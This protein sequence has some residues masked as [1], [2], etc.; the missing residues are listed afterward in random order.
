MIGLSEYG[1]DSDLE[2][3]LGARAGD[4]FRIYQNERAVNVDL[5]M[6]CLLFTEWIVA[7][8]AA[9]WLSPAIWHKSERIIHPHLWMAIIGGFSIVSLPI[10]LVWFYRGRT[11]T[12]HAVAVGQMLMSA[13]FIDISGGRIETHFH[14]FG[15]LAFLAFYRDWRILLTASAV[16]VL[17]HVIRGIWLPE[18]IYGMFT[19]SPWR[20]LEHAWWVATEDAVL[21]LSCHR[22]IREMR[23]IATREAQLWNSA[24]HDALTGLFNRRML[25]AK[26]QSRVRKEMKA[27]QP[28]SVIFI[29]LDRFKEVNDTL[30]HGIGD[31]LLIEV[32]RRLEG[33]LQG[34]D[35]V[36]R[37]GGDE[38]VLIVER[39][40]KS[41]EA[42][43]PGN[44]ILK[45]FNTPFE[46]E[47]H[48]LFLT[49]SIGIS[50]YPEHGSSLEELLDKADIAMYDAQFE[51]RN[52]VTL[53]SSTRRDV[54]RERLE[55]KRSLSQ[56][57][58]R[59][60]ISVEFQPIMGRN[61]GVQ[62]FEA[63]MRWNPENKGR[64]S[65][66]VFIPLA[67]STG[68]IVSLGEWVLR[69]ACRE[70]SRWQRPGDKMISVAV[71]VSAVQLADE[72]FSETVESTLAQWGMSPGMLTL[73]VTETAL[74]KDMRQASKQLKY[75]R[76]KGITV[77]L[78]DF[79]TGYS[80]LSYLQELPADKIKIDRSFVDRELQNGCKVLASI[81]VMAHRL[82]LKVVAEGVETAEQK[83]FLS[84][85]ECDELQGYYFSKPLPACRVAQ[86]LDHEGKR[87]EVEY[88]D[89]GLLALAVSGASRV[90]EEQEFVRNQSQLRL[91][92][93]ER[94]DLETVS[95]R[96][97]QV[98]ESGVRDFRDQGFPGLKIA[99]DRPGNLG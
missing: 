64:I 9:V 51:G 10:F 43:E 95:S 48:R 98:E 39:L 94:G 77:A 42:Q 20:W 28:V 91:A 1:S 75:L 82:G 59:E 57:L 14:I 58:L 73:E 26:F 40:Q 35:L 17:D 90:N 88:D 81:I 62:S 49:A 93:D 27:A 5:A 8:I 54:A 55:L 38:F 34:S 52:R 56:A 19:V 84:F 25:F 74:L 15:S 53:Y 23:V 68:L 24:Y 41:G 97:L 70:C 11:F 16:T 31:K 69:E 83:E 46:I 4:H 65:P 30:G 89:L 45:I 99:F 63:L 60:E 44:Q 6:A 13:L 18:S 2:T 76:E 96:L 80:S 78:D 33:L 47:G 87:R 72:S 12:R 71:N 66:D 61:G 79:G 36:V 3:D 86:F 32:S 7:I 21:V 29:D 92:G 85:L 67:E 37:L 50:L 22:S